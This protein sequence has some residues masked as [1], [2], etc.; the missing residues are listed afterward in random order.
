MSF[1][2]FRLPRTPVE[3]KPAD[4]RAIREERRFQA[5]LTMLASL[6]DAEAHGYLESCRAAVRLA[7]TF[8]D[9]LDNS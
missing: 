8:L 9:V 1:D 3:Y 5:A 2:D 7:D 4:H 6:C